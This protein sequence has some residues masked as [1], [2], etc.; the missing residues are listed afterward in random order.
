MKTTFKTAKRKPI[1]LPEMRVV[2]AKQIMSFYPEYFVTLMVNGFI[3]NMSK[4]M[5]IQW[6]KLYGYCY[7]SEKPIACQHFDFEHTT[8]NALRREGRPAHWNIALIQAHKEKTRRDVH[9]IAKS[10]RVARKMGIDKEINP[11]IRK[12]KSRWQSRPMSYATKK[13]KFNGEV[14]DR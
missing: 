4:S 2:I 9:A 5:C 3:S 10:K 8:P 11:I 13:R 12:H 1:T 6:F 7:L 14:V